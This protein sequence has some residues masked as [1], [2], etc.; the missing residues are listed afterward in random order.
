VVICY[1][2]IFGLFFAI[3]GLFESKKLTLNLFFLL[4]LEGTYYENP[5]KLIK[6]S[7]FVEFGT[8]FIE[9]DTRARAWGG[10]AGFNS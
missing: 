10:K 2:S 1:V 4:L 8:P 6:P 7:G 3:C 5:P 9:A